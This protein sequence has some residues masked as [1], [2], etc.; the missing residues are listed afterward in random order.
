MGERR[1]K[2]LFFI[3]AEGVKTEPIYFDIFTDETSVVRVSY[4][5]GKHDSSPSQVLKRM[6]DHLKNK[7]LK[8]YICLVPRLYGSTQALNSRL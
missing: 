1:Y 6:T 7:E 5:K 2:K 3:A 4:L 8:L